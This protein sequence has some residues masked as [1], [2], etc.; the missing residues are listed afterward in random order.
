MLNRYTHLQ[1]ETLARKH[2][3]MP[4][5]QI[6]S[7]FRI[8]ILTNDHPPPHVHVVGRGGRAKVELDCASGSAELLWFEGIARPDL[9]R[10]I[11]AI[12]GDI[13]WLC[14]EWRRIHGQT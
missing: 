12:E 7:G 5:I 4:T 14:S 9:R 2:R 11:E 6:V 1:A 13:E 10:I 8:M 3:L